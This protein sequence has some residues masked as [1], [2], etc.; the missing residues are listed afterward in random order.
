MD[1]YLKHTPAHLD[2]HAHAHTYHIHTQHTETGVVYSM[3]SRTLIHTSIQTRCTNRCA[4]QR[5]H[6]PPPRSISLSHTRTPT[7]SQSYT[8]TCQYCGQ[9]FIKPLRTHSPLAVF[10]RQTTRNDSRW[11]CMTCSPIRPRLTQQLCFSLRL[12]QAC[13]Y[14]LKEKRLLSTKKNDWEWLKAPEPGL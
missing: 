13:S 9:A 12:H 8:T 10:G 7:H 5:Q 3:L 1:V 2:R 6:T 14:E 11:K 4:C